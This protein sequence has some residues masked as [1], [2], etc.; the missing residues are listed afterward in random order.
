ME[1]DHDGDETSLFQGPF[2]TSRS[3]MKGNLGM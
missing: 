2:S 3:D 1:I